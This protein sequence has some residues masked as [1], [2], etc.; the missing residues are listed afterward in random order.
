MDRKNKS[1][2]KS[3]LLSSSFSKGKL[4]NQLECRNSEA[5]CGA[6]IKFKK[7]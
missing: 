6:I 4:G 3:K 1:L 7:Q 2:K 5:V